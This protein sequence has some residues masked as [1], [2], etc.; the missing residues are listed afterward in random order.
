MTH[1]DPC[2]DMC[3]DQYVDMCADMRAIGCI[4]L[5][6]CMR[7]DSVSIDSFS[8][9]KVPPRG[10]KLLT[11]LSFLLVVVNT[12]HEEGSSQVITVASGMV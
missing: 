8:A 4:R 10:A 5:G 12:V 11:D 6:T 7:I 9:D 3:I 1:V 2:V